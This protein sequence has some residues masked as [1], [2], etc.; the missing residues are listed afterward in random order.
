MVAQKANLSFKNKY[1]YI[2]VTD[3]A[4][5]LK[6]GKLLG[7]AKAHHKITPREKSGRGWPWDREAPKYLGF[8]INISATAALSSSVSGASCC[9]SCSAKMI[10][11]TF[12]DSKGSVATQL[13]CGDEAFYCKFLAE[14]KSE[15]ILKIGKHLAE[16]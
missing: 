9:N 13:R 10:K 8:P 5:D 1:P 6:F 12:Y 4:S 3:E 16:L 2:S 7:F 15:R 11:V 14:S